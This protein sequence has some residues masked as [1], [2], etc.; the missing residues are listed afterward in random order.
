MRSGLL[1][2][3][4]AITAVALI[5][6]LRPLRLYPPDRVPANRKLLV[7]KLL[8]PHTLHCV[9]GDELTPM[10]PQALVAQAVASGPARPS[11]TARSSSP[12]A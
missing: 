3:L 11:S 4:M 2:A 5:V 8:L 10:C 12:T 6:A 9:G 1:L 7:L